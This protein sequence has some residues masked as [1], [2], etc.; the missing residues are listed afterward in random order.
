MTRER[1]LLEIM[2]EIERTPFE[3]LSPEAKRAW[4]AAFNEWA[5]ATAKVEKADAQS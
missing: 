5:E 4:T 3:A 2:F 1:E